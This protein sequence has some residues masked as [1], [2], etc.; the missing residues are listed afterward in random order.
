MELNPLHQVVPMSDP[1]DLP[2]LGPGGHLQ[3][4]WEGMFLDDKGMVANRLEGVGNGSVH[5]AAVVKD[6]RG[7]PVHNPLSP[8]H[9]AP[10][11]RG[12]RLVSKAY[13]EHGDGSAEKRIASTE[14]PASAGEQG[15]GD[16]TRAAGLSAFMLGTS[17]LSLRY[18]F[19]S[20]FRHSRS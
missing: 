11:G 8:H 10:V 16:M 1:H 4:R 20:W 7:L 6:D 18:T 15:P 2:L 14:T 19:T 3:A 13:P 12:N 5:G 17:I 9:P